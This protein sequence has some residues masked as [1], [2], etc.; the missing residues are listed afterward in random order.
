MFYNSLKDSLL[1]VETILSSIAEL[2]DTEAYEAYVGQR[3]GCHVRHVVDHF[4]ALLKLSESDTIDYNL[5]SR[6]SLTETDIAYARNQISEVIDRLR[7]A[8]FGSR[9]VVCISEIDV[10]E[11]KSVALKSTA[12]REALWVFNHT[13]HHVALIKVLAEQ[14][15]LT[16]NSELGVAPATASSVREKR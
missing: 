2:P 3:I 9:E 8:S 16:F 4:I 1:Q 12:D 6:N 14:S 15:G 10:S 7:S 13:I 11:T 5:R